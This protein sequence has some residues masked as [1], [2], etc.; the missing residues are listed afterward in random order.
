[1][2]YLQQHAHCVVLGYCYG[3]FLA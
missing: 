2:K 3:Q 1:M